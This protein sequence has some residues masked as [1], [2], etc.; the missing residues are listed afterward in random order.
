MDLTFTPQG[1]LSFI[2]SS[3]GFPRLPLISLDPTTT[4]RSQ[5]HALGGKALYY[6]FL[7][8]QNVKIR[9]LEVTLVNG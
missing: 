6:L 3:M 1:K 7:S 5:F 8:S 2:E 9:S 4:Y